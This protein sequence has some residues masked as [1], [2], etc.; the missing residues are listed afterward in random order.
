M[1]AAYIAM[2]DVRLKFEM[3]DRDLQLRIE[4]KHQELK[5]LQRELE[6]LLKQQLYAKL[7]IEACT[8]QMDKLQELG[9]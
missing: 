8:S 3:E 9:L 5:D 6:T 4:R 2:R 7:Q 1:S